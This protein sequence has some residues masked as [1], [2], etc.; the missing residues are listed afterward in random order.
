MFQN[1]TQRGEENKLFSL[2]WIYQ[3]RIT[4]KRSF[5]QNVKNTLII[6]AQIYS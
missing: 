3:A 5:S 6:N 4:W 1:K 2:G